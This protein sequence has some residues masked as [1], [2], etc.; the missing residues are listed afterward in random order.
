MPVGLRGVGKTVL[1]NRF[2]EEAQSL[3]LHVALM[4]APEDLDLRALLSR[5]SR[6]LL[7]ALDRAGK[8]SHAVKRALRVFKSFS[9]TL[10]PDGG[11]SL[12]VDVD[13]E[14]GI[15][16]S[17][18][19]SDDVSDLFQALGEAARDRGTGIVLAIDEVQYLSREGLSALIMAIHRST[20]LQ[21]PLVL[22]G[23]GLPQLP[24]LAGN[25]KSYAER[26]F[27]FP[28][29]DSLPEEEAKQA[30]FRP[31]EEQGVHFDPDALAE[32]V[33]RT[34]GYPYFLQE[35]AYEVW[36][37]AP[38]K[39]IRM[40]DVIDAGP[41]VLKK[42]DQN[43]FRVRFDRLTPVERRYLRAMAELGPGP[44]RSGDIA[45]THGTSVESAGPLR[46][47]L[48]RK[49]MIY[50]PSHG[51]TA[52][53]APLF[54]EFLK[55]ALPFEHRIRKNNTATPAETDIQE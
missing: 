28:Q 52:F 18:E 36:N 11:V 23:A 6:R 21:L 37:V 24:A 22:V 49:G 4:E 31:A 45:T 39:R 29:I 8:V 27:T 55:R 51:D 26:L 43:F 15:A 50:S 19:L 32:I 17:G 2:R 44:H 30:V 40:I 38:T 20:Q 14:I 42:L 12:G 54:D 9:L 47:G 33:K 41:I 46:S 25:A 7:L 53:T 16:D 1:L 35:W 13:P 48:I 10:N 5:E 34:H 3:K